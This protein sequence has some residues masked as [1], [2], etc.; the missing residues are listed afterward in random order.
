MKWKLISTIGIVYLDCPLCLVEVKS[1][2]LYMSP[3][4]RT[5]FEEINVLRPN[6]SLSVDMSPSLR[7]N[8]PPTLT[9]LEVL[10]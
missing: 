10:G 1:L 8:L 7:L 4:Y 3:H 2:S 5:K 6:H 9:N